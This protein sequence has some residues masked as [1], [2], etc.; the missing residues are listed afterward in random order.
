ML[1]YEFLFDLALILISTKLFGLI[2]KKV[3]MPQVV[4]ALVAGVILGPAVLNVLSET[5]FIQKLAEL[6]VIVLMFTAGLETDI[7]QL[8]KTTWRNNSSCRRIFY[9]KY[10]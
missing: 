7:N 9:C 5:E 6:G 1:S 2:T 3:R 10:I 8:K 4:G